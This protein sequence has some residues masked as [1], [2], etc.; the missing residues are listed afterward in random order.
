MW[1]IG[2]RLAAAM[3]SRIC[4]MDRRLAARE[5]QQVRLAL[6][7][8]QRIHH[9]L[10]LGQRPVRGALGGGIGEA[11]GAGEVAGLVDVDQR[12]AGMLLMVGAEPAVIGAAQLGARLHVERPVARLQVVMAELVI[13]GIGGDQRLLHAMRLAALEVIDVVLL[14]DDLG[15]HQRH[16]GAAHRGGLAI[17]H[18]GR[19]L[20]GGRVHALSSRRLEQIGRPVLPHDG[21][22]RGGDRRGRRR[23]PSAGMLMPRKPMT[24]ADHNPASAMKTRNSTCCSS[25]LPL[26]ACST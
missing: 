17:E 19:D 18:I 16:A 3:I 9:A 26:R 24:P 20:A 14:D 6:G 22:G 5:L 7:C 1:R 2:R 15:R 4:G 11:H 12:Q 8:D 21:D 23:S 10:D 25:R 13:G